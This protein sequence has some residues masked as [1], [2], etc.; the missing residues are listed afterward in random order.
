MTRL[1][2]MKILNDHVQFLAQ[3]YQFSKCIDTERNMALKPAIGLVW[4]YMYRQK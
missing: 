1:C 3:I 4:L 2:V